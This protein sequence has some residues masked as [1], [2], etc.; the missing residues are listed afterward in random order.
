MRTWV[1]IVVVLIVAFTVTNLAMGA[2]RL[3]AEHLS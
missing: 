3:M 1:F 2:L